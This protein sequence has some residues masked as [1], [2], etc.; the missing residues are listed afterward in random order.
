[1]S[2]M[3]CFLENLLDAEERGREDERSNKPLTPAP[4]PKDFK[5]LHPA[6]FFSANV[7]HEH[8]VEGRDKAKQ[9]KQK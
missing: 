2:R 3:Q 6:D 4:D 5:N 9:E 7:Y 1:M 8:Y